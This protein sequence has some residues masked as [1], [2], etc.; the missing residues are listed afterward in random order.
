VLYF[1]NYGTGIVIPLSDFLDFDREENDKLTE[2]FRIPMPKQDADR[3]WIWLKKHP[4][5]ATPAN[6]LTWQKVSADARIS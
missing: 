4:H 3:T 5:A 6:L 1:R 2:H